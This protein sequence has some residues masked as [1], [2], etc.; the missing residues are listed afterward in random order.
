MEYLYHRVP[1]NMVGTILYPLNQLKSLYPD[2]YA[3]EAKKYE[4][5][6]QLLLAE[7]P[8]LHCLWNDVLH[9]TAVAPDEVRANLAL[10][11]FSYPPRAWFKIPIERVL[12][13][14][15]IAFT[16]R[17]DKDVHPSF[18]DYEPF[19]AERMEVYRTVPSETIEYYKEMKALGKHPLLFHFVPHI[20]YKGTIDIEGLEIIIG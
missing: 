16:Y 1:P 14:N 6:E 18:K 8:P 15:S 20:L 12:G 7:V 13:E 2:L 17:R 3:E 19:S 10:A 11:D 4:G 5:R 9:M